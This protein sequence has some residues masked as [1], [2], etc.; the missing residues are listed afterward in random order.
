[1]LR[2]LYNYRRYI[3][4]TFWVDLKYRYSGT[5]LGF[6]WFLVNPMIEVLIYAVVFSQIITFRS[7]AERGISYTIFLVSGLFPFIAFSQTI[8]R[9]SKAIRTNALYMRRS[10][11]PAEV[12]VFKESLIAGFSLLVYLMFLLPLIVF[13]QNPVS[14]HLI[15][16][17]ILTILLS[18][19]GYGLSLPLANLSVL[20]PDLE[21][22]VPVLLQLWRWTLP[23]MF[24]DENFPDGLRWFMSFNPPYYFI[25]SFR[26]IMINQ[27]IPPVESWI[28]MI[29]WIIVTLIVGGLV[30]NRLRSDVKDLI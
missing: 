25:K 20:F 24:S 4:G 22:V 17:P 21:E 12:F 9:G 18:L 10:L 29:F 2:T 11:I 23:I 26:D 19:L 14:W 28:I 30:T 8:N 5:T 1:M 13:T 15:L 6:F 16:W 27:R 7:G 3:F